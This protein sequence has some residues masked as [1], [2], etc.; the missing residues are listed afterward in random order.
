MTRRANLP[1]GPRGGEK[2]EWEESQGGLVVCG[3]CAIR[4][5]GG[6]SMSEVRVGVV[7]Q[8]EA[9]VWG[10]QRDDTIALSKTENLRKSWNYGIG[11]KVRGGLEV[12]GNAAGPNSGGY[13]P[14]HCTARSQWPFWG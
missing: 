13:C 1:S 10:R 6:Q 11:F 14:Q 9:Q 3:G 7:L 5:S 8:L 12:T 2:L 4:D